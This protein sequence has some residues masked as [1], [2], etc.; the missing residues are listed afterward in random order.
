MNALVDLA[1]VS[2]SITAADTA[3]VTADNSAEQTFEQAVEQL[4]SLIV[5]KENIKIYLEGVR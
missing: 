2:S 5:E 4:K 1:N 3:S